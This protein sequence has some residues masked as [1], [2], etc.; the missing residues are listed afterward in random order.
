MAA[1]LLL[2]VTILNL[3]APAF[4]HLTKLICM[5][6]TLIV[7]LRLR[8]VLLKLNMRNQYWHQCLSQV[9]CRG[10]IYWKMILCVV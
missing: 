9:C 6:R 3:A 4:V 2:Q 1:A 10:R 5:P 7:T 8:V